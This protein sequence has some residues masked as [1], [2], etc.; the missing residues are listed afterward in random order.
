M[1][2]LALPV[3]L[4]GC[5]YVAPRTA[6]AEL[7]DA[8]G[9]SAGQVTFS[10]AAGG[11]QVKVRVSGLK[12]G[13]HG[14]HIHANPDCT[15]TT[16]TSG[17]VTIFGGAGGHFDPAQ[18]QH[19]AGPAASNTQGHGGDLPM[20]NVGSDGVGNAEFLSAKIS[21]EGPTSVIGRSVIVHAEPDDYKTDPAGNSGA[22]ER[23]GII[24]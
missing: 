8:S 6:T 4:A 12:P 19:H 2:S 18:A 15:N 24:R 13:L 21:L 16:D 1:L 22:R 9:K 14:M 17:K 7:L 3:L 5:T 10:P 23:C 20:L 11:T